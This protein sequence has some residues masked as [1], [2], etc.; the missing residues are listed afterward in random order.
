M[1]RII[2]LLLTLVTLSVEAH[3][4]NRAG[5]TFS[6]GD[7]GQY[8]ALLSGALVG[9][10][11]EINQNYGETAYSDVEAFKALVVQHVEKTVN[12]RFNDTPVKFENVK[13]MLGHE[14]NI[15]ASVT[16]VPEPIESIHL[17]NTFFKD[18]FRS[19]LLV[20]FSGDNLPTKRYVLNDSN[21]YT[22]DIRLHNTQ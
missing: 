17:T 16:G 15:I 4:A 7:D 3:Q 20:I 19:K 10:E 8:T 14:T 18:I 13:V 2:F 12:L 21:Q 1:K 11:A 5:F 6:K 22:L 9:V